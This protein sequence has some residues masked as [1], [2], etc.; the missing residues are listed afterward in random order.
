MAFS[1]AYWID[2]KGKIF[3]VGTNHVTSI[4]KNPSHFKTTTK[5]VTDT[6]AKYGERIG[7]EAEARKDLIFEALKLGFVRIRAYRGYWAITVDKLDSK[8][9]SK[10]KMWANTKEVHKKFGVYHPV[11]LNIVNNHRKEREVSVRKLE[12]GK[13][14]KFDTIQELIDMV[15]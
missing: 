1:E 2:D 6:Y 3:D 5:H 10:I 14:I 12:D 11:K 15:N 9:R 7:Q 4:I 8:T 13:L